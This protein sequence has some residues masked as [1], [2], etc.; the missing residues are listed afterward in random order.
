[1][2]KKIVF[3]ALML[4]LPTI[5]FSKEILTIYA[6]N[7][8]ISKWGPGP[9]IKEAFEKE[10]KC[11]LK[12]IGLGGGA[13]ILNRLRLEGKNTKADIVLGLDT[14]NLIQAKKLGLIGKHDVK[15]DKI[16]MPN[17]WNDEYFLPLDF[18]YYAFVYDSSK[19]KN[20]PKSMDEF[21][22]QKNKVIYQDPRT[23][24]VG[25]GLVSWIEK[26]YPKKSQRGLEKVSEKNCNCNKRLV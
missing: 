3:T 22:N 6:P 2:F 17:G 7:S 14:N 18:G 5:S 15:T 21:L 23:S 9:K 20:P 16:N 8:F 4:L 26:I 25:F 13:T 11:E 12:F 10:C 24:T 1:M 19:I